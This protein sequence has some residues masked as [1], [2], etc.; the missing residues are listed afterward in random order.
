M[1]CYSEIINR[2]C[3]GPSGRPNYFLDNHEKKRALGIEDEDHFKPYCEAVY[4]QSFSLEQIRHS[5]RAST[6]RIRNEICT[7]AKR[8]KS[9]FELISKPS[10]LFIVS[11]LWEKEELSKKID[12]INSSYIMRLF[13]ENS[14]KRQ[15]AKKGDITFMALNTVERSYF[16]RGIAAFMA[17]NDLPNQ[18]STADLNLCIEQLIEAIPDEFSISITLTE[19]ELGKPLKE[20]LDWDNSRQS[21]LHFI[22]NDVRSCGLLVNDL[23]K[24]GYFKFS[25]KSFLEFLQSELVYNLFSEE[26]WLRNTSISTL[27]LTGAST[28]ELLNSTVIMSFLL[29][30]LRTKNVT[31]KKYKKLSTM[32]LVRGFFGNDERKQVSAELSL[33]T[34]LFDL[35]VVGENSIHHGAS[36]KRNFIKIRIFFHNLT[37]VNEGRL[38]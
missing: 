29:D 13:I 24:E 32:S 31:D 38:C 5:L 12:V 26:D 33:A 1:T 4:L 2:V 9:F 17:A 25:H 27:N 20:R 34:K 14:Y 11:T 15:S 10:L 3:S 28:R 35:M 18:I 8:D 6:E 30:L 7:I 21:S 23:V 37:Y 16:M 36:L 22:K 19:D